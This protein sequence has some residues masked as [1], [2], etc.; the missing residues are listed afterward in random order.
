M[1]SEEFGVITSPRP[2]PISL[3][4]DLLIPAL[5]VLGARLLST[6]WARTAGLSSTRPAMPTNIDLGTRMEAPYGL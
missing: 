6:N 5:A 4:R 1:N 3:A 2:G